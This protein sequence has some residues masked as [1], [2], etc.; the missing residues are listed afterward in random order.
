MDK[1]QTDI[2][3]FMDSYITYLN[4]QLTGTINWWLKHLQNA[5]LQDTKAIIQPLSS[6]LL[7]VQTEVTD[8]SRMVDSFNIELPSLRQHMLQT[9]SSKH[10]Q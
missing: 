4:S 6:T 3:G 10:R 5:M 7:Q 1:Q 8:C 2:R 9:G